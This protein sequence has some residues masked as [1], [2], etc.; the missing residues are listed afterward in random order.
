[1]KKVVLLSAIA[2]GAIA[3]LLVFRAREETVAVLNL[4]W[5]ESHGI[6]TFDFRVANL[7]KEE[8][9][10]SVELIA[11]RTIKLRAGPQIA[12][13]GRGRAEVH[14]AAKEEKKVRGQIALDSAA[15]GTLSLVP[16]VT[17]KKPNQ[18]PEPAPKAVTPPAAQEA[19]QP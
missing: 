10:V 12:E 8:V 18:A 7:T 17:V 11:E 4:N 2:I 16:H 9:V 19:H 13:A 14:L 6:V 1:M 15:V 5:R 3:A